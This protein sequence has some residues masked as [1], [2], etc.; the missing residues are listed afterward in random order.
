MIFPTKINDRVS[1]VQD[2]ENLRDDLKTGA[3]TVPQMEEFYFG[4]LLSFLD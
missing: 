4:E 1:Y 2:Q 3:F